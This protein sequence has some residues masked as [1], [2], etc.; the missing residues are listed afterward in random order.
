MPY[1]VR[2]MPPRIYIT[3]IGLV[4]AP[5]DG[6]GL[7]PDPL[8]NG[9]LSARTPVEPQP[10]EPRL[11]ALARAASERA[12]A[13]APGLAALAPEDKG[14]YV[15]SSKGGMEYFDGPAPDLGPSLWRYLSS[16][17]GQALRA[18]LGWTG[19]GRNTPLACAT[20]AYS[21]GQ[22]FEDLRLGR[23]KAALAGAAEASL[24]PLIV[25]AFDNIGALSPARRV[26]DLRG[27]FDE[28]AHGFV[29][30]EAGAALLLESE[31][32]LARTGHRPLVELLGWACTCD[33]YHMTA[34]DPRG[35]QAARA[36]RLALAMAGVAAEDVAYVNAHGT[37]TPSGDKAELNVL[38][39]VFG[40]G[41]GPRVSSIKGAVGHTLGASGA[42]EAAV[43]V[44]S[45]AGGR[46]PGNRGC[47][48]PLP[49][50]A[51]WLALEDES[52]AGRVAVSMSMGFG[53][54]NVALVFGKV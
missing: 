33:A 12:L 6:S 31:D 29:V 49:G 38:R 41:A 53:G 10:G 50:L 36:M 32:G 23:L 8:L 26:E 47:A 30:G 28:A 44:R 48:A 37:G 39:G 52:L 4:S 45:L 2:P 25:A 5:L 42:L 16:S 15:S 19:P 35:S 21:V 54:H 9:R 20:G 18:G 40:E 1:S 24:T 14:V 46:L 3:S 17:P 51:P 34:P 22:A 7:S 13:Q 11:H 27:P 43:T